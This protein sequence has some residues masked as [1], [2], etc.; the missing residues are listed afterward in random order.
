VKFKILIIISFFLIFIKINSKF[1]CFINY[2]NA[3]NT[4]ERF[5]NA[6]HY[7]EVDRLP[8][9][10]FGY[11]DE[12]LVEWKKQGLPQEISND[13]DAER[14]FGFDYR[15]EIPT[16]VHLIPKYEEKIIS[17][18]P[19]YVVHRDFEGI[20]SEKPK[21]T[22]SIPKYLKYPIENRDDW[23]EYKKRF[24]PETPER[25]PSNLDELIKEY[26][27]RDY[28]LGIYCGSLYGK[29]R[30][31]LGVEN[32]ST[33]LYD[34]RWLI[35][36]MMETFTEV[37]LSVLNK[38][39]PKINLDFSSWWEDICYNHGTLISPKIFEELAV[40]RYRKII[41]LLEKH[42]VDIH[43]LDCDGKIDELV[44]LWMNCGIKCMFPVEAAHS[45]PLK[46]KEKY[47]KDICILGGVNKVSLIKGKEA[48]DEEILK[49]KKLISL[50]G[51]IPH[52]DH[53][54][55]PDVTLENYY[56]YIKKKREIL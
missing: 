42:G 49:L 38:I 22:S 46:L 26:K 39:L 5:L 36:D 50:G 23:M 13:W 10:E 35:E 1:I 31:L 2:L 33:M 53:R 34:D 29:I 56:Y 3:M 44:P 30:D 4:R 15:I 28:P 7:K 48:I 11:W 17:E 55:P 21:T 20:I 16:S 32:V 14:Y 43:Y 6:F 27:N 40:P 8:D 51:F 52:V 19:D 47:G 41:D 12:T 9:F 24:N 54:V 37:A 18:T 25:I 45:D